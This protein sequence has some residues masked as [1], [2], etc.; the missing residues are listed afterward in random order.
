MIERGFVTSLIQSAKTMAQEVVTYRASDRATIGVPDL[1]VW[2]QLDDG[3]KYSGAV[4]A[5]QLRPLMEDPFHRGRRTGMML[6]HPFSGPQ[7][8]M[9]LKL[10]DA[11]VDACG[12]VRVSDDTAFR[13]EPDDIPA[14]TG[15]FTHEELVRFGSEVVR[16]GGVWRFWRAGNDSKIPHPRY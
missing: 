14:K 3:L 2:A 9:L 5:K 11:G 12:L 10:R 8:S 4:E 1:L 15:N 13:I 7:I 6:K 16:E